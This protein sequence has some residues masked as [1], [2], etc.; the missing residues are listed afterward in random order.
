MK[1]YKWDAEIHYSQGK[2]KARFFVPDLTEDLIPPLYAEAVKEYVLSKR[3]TATSFQ[4][5]QNLFCM[6]TAQRLAEKQEG[7]YELLADVRRFIDTLL[8]DEEKSQVNPI[9][10][11]LRQLPQAIA[12]GYYILK[13][14]ITEMGGLS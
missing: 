5:F 8:T 3:A 6:T 13:S 10:T 1:K 2:E 12:I 7:P 14:I 4:R 9:N 11:E